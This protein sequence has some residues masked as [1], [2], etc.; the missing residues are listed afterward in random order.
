MK[1]NQPGVGGG[2]LVRDPASKTMKNGFVM[3]PTPG[4]GM[5]PDEDDL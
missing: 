4:V 1:L 3:Y 5:R 2:G